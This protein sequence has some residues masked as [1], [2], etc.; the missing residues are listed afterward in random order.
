MSGNSENRENTGEESEKAETLSRESEKQ[1]NLSPG[2]EKRETM[3]DYADHFDDANPWNIVKKYMA[4]ETVLTLKV[5]GV[6]KGGVI[7]KVEGIRGFVPASHLSLSY[8]KNLED[9]LLKDIEVQVI[10][11]NQSE[12]RLVLS[13]RKVLKEKEKKE[14]DAMIEHVAVGSV[15]KGTVESVQSY[16]AFVR[17]ENGLS[18]LIH[19]SQ[20]SDK[21][22]KS[23]GEVLKE[24]DEVEVKVIGK[25]DGKISLSRKAALAAPKEEKPPKTQLPPSEKIG[26][27]LGELFRKLNL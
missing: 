10:E 18:G 1:E 2:A 13:A 19:I 5:E 3:A 7:V 8:V 23:V 11:V 12:G 9:F 17:L 15:L 22:V 25:K 6:V 27:N 21:R 16:G 4:D 14:K 20:L 24:G 26:T